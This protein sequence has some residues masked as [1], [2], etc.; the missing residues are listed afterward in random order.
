MSSKRVRTS[1]VTGEKSFQVILEVGKDENGKRLKKHKTFHNEKEADMF[2]H[3]MEIEM[4]NG[5]FVRPSPISVREVSQIWLESVKKNGLKYNTIRGYTVNVERHIIP[6]I[7][8]IPI[9]K[10]M[11]TDIKRLIANMQKEGLSTTT[12]KYVML[13]L[14]QILDYAVERHLLRTSPLTGVRIPKS[15]PFK[16]QTYTV[17]ELKTLL[18]VSKG[19]PLE[20][21]LQIEVNTGLRIGELLALK[22]SDIDFEKNEISIKG[23]VVY[24]KGKGSVIGTPKSL[25]STRTIPVSASLIDR[26]KLLKAEESKQLSK[27][28]KKWCLDDMPVIHNKKWG[29]CT[30][31]K[32]SSDFSKL[33][34]ENNLRHIRFHDLRK[35]HASVLA[36]EYNVEP[37]AIRER[38]GH[39]RVS[40]TMNCYIG[41]TAKQQI[42]GLSK[43]ELGLNIGE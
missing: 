8:S 4:Y 29:L 33:L 2:L 5:T 12:V 21:I 35:S 7:G 38:L 23:T 3:Q 11:S 19:T 31:S 13:N 18:Q 24:Q 28:N 27:F 41:G 20:I 42:D 17:D 25:S 37:Y 39:S 14:R 15:R 6:N 40:T 36:L 30:A 32:I 9:Q 1:P 26:L 43:L 34:R 16:I 22:W 10:L